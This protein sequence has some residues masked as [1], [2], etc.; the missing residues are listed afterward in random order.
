MERF[1]RGSVHPHPRSR[2]GGADCTSLWAGEKAGTQRSAEESLEEASWWSFEF[3]VRKIWTKGDMQVR[4]CREIT[5]E[6]KV[7]SVASALGL[8]VQ[9]RKE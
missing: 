5:P 4:C 9:D 8:Y 1:P 6:E 7:T 2:P 3:G